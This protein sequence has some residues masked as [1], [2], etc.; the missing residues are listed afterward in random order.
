MIKDFS[1]DFA[2]LKDSDFDDPLGESSGAG[3]IFGSSG[4]VLESALNSI[5]YDYK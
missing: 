4:G 3:V 5:Q 1:L 2:G